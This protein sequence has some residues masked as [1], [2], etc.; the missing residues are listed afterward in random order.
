MQ[1]IQRNRE[2]WH[3]RRPHHFSG[4]LRNQ[5]RKKASIAREIDVNPTGSMPKEQC[6]A[7]IRA[8]CPRAIR[9]ICTRQKR[10]TRFSLKHSTRSH[11]ARS[12]GF[13]GNYRQKRGSRVQ[14]ALDHAAV[15][16]I[17]CHDVGHIEEPDSFP[18]FGNVSKT[19]RSED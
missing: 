4:R 10:P 11:A 13:P 6:H 15:G 17:W 2:I 7:A 9:A 16:S 3:N 5:I 8:I 19:F 12:M 18:D 1:A 14:R